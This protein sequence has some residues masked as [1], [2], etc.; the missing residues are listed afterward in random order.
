MATTEATSPPEIYRQAATCIDADPHDFPFALIYQR[1]D[2]GRLQLASATGIARGTEA[3]PESV[4]PAQDAA[5]SW[6][7]AEL[8]AS[9][10]GFVVD[11]LDARF[12]GLPSGV[13]AHPPAQAMILPIFPQ[14]R[15]EVAGLVV[16]ALNP[17]R[18]VDEA[19]RGF[20]DLVAGQ[21]S[22]AVAHALAYETE[23][24]RAEALA[25]IDRA[26]TTFFSNVSHEFRTPLT[27]MLG[28][29]EDALKEPR[30]GGRDSAR[31]PSGRASKR[32]C[33]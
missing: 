8:A 19:F 28:P 17:Y 25:E 9:P 11:N 7:F 32:R 26:K 12:G 3:S 18:P 1:T 22:A 27:L 10:A 2:E 31:P 24:K 29:L 6:P 30:C 13:W 4:D 33:A 15:T 23:R 20:C 5:K 16:L 21:I 14:G